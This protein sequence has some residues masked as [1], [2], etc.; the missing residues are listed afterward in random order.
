MQTTAL[1][2]TACGYTLTGLTFDNRDSTCS[3]CGRHQPAAQPAPPPPLI[4]WA[5]CACLPALAVWTIGAIALLGRFMLPS[6][7]GQFVS[8]GTTCAVIAPVLHATFHHTRVRNRPGAAKVAL[9][10]LL[11]G[12]MDNLALFLTLAFVAFIVLSTL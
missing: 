8:V 1:T 10:T 4:E 7:I 5:L 2:C 12:W 11:A 6:D 3:E 9:V